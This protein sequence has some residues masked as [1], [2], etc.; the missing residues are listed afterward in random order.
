[1][2]VGVEGS[3][4]RVGNLGA[5]EDERPEPGRGGMPPGTS[6]IILVVHPCEMANEA[7][8]AR[9]RH[10]CAEPL[11]MFPDTVV[12]FQDARVGLSHLHS[13]ENTSDCSPAPMTVNRSPVPPDP[14]AA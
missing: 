5:V 2:G 6:N 10:V 12:R 11:P 13:K 4:F 3:E 7:E 1:M 9:L 14:C 8:P